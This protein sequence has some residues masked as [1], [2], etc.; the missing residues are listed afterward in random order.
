MQE[1]QDISII[2]DDDYFDKDEIQKLKEKL[3]RLKMNIPE[4]TI[5]TKVTDKKNNITIK[6]LGY[7]IL[8]KFEIDSVLPDIYRKLKPKKGHTYEY[9]TYF[10]ASD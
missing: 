4:P 1:Y 8:T 5:I 7:R 10:G 9:T 6:I 3:K 2:P